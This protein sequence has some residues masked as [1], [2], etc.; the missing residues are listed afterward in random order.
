MEENEKEKIKRLDATFGI[1]VAAVMG[2]LLNL[3]AN[4]Y[5]DLF[6]TSLIK[7]EEI[8]Q[9]QI[10]YISLSLIGLFGFL[11]FFIN[12]YRNEFGINKSFF[13]RYVNYFFYKF[14]P[15][16]IIGF[17]FGV[18]TL[19]FLLVLMIMT[20]IFIAEIGGILAAI[21]IFFL[22]L[23]LSYSKDKREK[24]MKKLG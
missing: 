24:I 20:F 23:I 1:I 18:Y 16:K 11:L 7:W 17:I 14:G 12:D 5:Y 6:I 2:F 8:N 21:S 3:L 22:I 10:F 4:A 15:G 19:L 13:K 9:S